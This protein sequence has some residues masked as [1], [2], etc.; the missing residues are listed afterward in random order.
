V[1]FDLTTPPGF[2]AGFPLETAVVQLNATGIADW[3]TA[4]NSFI[5]TAHPSASQGATQ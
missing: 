5:F 1:E 2:A 3:Q 4:T